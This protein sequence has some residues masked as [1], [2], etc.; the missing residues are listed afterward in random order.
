MERSNAHKSKMQT[1][2]IIQFIGGICVA[3]CALQ[4]ADDFASPVGS[5]DVQSGSI[6]K[7][8]VV[9]DFLYV[10]DGRVLKV[11]SIQTPTNPKYLGSIEVG[12]GLETLFGLGDYLF[13]GSQTGMYI[14]NI[15]ES[16]KPELLS[17]YEHI[18]SCDPVVA[19]S[20]YAYVTLRAG[21][22]CGS[23][24][25]GVNELH[26]ISIINPR[27]PQAISKHSMTHPMGLGLD[28]NMLF[29]CDQGNG[30]VIFDIDEHGIPM[31]RNVIFMDEP[32][33]VIAHNGHLIVVTPRRVLQFNY[34]DPD[35][36]QLLSQF[37]HGV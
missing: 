20:E 21:N 32:I 18:S 27:S 19:D 30:V 17:H 11:H 24:I 31:Q 23:T 22:R 12:F 33:D 28:D 35:N 25:F 8:K 4:C 6:T 7:F 34:S 16:W 14:H 13:I 3:M 37:E 5:G 29:V 9:K 10:I 36:V 15:R 26:T 1:V 2:K